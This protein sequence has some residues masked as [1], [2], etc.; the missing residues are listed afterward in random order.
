M[1]YN[2]YE[3]RVIF[4]T[5][6][7][8]GKPQLQKKT[9]KTMASWHGNLKKELSILSASRPFGFLVI[10]QCFV[11]TSDFFAEQGVLKK[12]CPIIQKND[13]FCFSIAPR[14]YLYAWTHFYDP[15]CRY[16]GVS[17]N[18]GTPKSSILIGC[19]IIFTIRFGIP[20][21]LVQHPFCF[22]SVKVTKATTT[23]GCRSWRWKGV[24][25]RTAKRICFNTG[26]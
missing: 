6:D 5:G 16:L 8:L 13:S 11:L 20:L 9:R 21:F 26:M 15:V 12:H 18:R 24:K 23:S 1:T 19:S 2:R 14:N 25:R 17:K 22:M 4:S 3:W 7:F 10:T